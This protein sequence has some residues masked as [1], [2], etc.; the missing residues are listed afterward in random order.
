MASAADLSSDC[1]MRLL[2]TKNRRSS[3][4][5]RIKEHSFHRLPAFSANIVEVL[6]DAVEQSF[7]AEACEASNWK[8]SQVQVSTGVTH[9]KEAL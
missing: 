2:L 1:H 9:C 4:R 8:V 3:E 7:L 5:P 6:L